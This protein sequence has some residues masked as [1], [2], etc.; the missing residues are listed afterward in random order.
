M[1]G[2]AVIAALH[3]PHPPKVR[4]QAVVKDVG[5]VPKDCR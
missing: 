5:R 4:T 3:S 1:R 2:K